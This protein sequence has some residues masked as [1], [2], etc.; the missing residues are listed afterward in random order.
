MPRPQAPAA[1][2]GQ[3]A[4]GPRVTPEPGRGCIRGN[5]RIR[6]LTVQLT[7][8]KHQTAPEFPPRK[9]HNKHGGDK[10]TGQNETIP[11]GRKEQSI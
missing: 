2:L 6:A 10:G 4:A 5:T 11:G 3:D 8:C 1:L 7:S 9:G